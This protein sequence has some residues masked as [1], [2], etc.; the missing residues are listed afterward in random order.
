MMPSYLYDALGDLTW[1]VLRL[2]ETRRSRSSNGG[3]SPV[4]GAGSCRGKSM[5]STGSS[6]A[7]MSRCGPRSTSASKFFH[8]TCKLR[9][10]ANQLNNQLWKLH[11]NYGPEGYLQLW[12]NNRF[13]SDAWQR[14]PAVLS[15][16]SA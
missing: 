3:M 7:W 2:L 6:Y 15:Q 8:A 10:F 11:G 12:K 4:A 16:T 5:G 14:L 9:Q 13:P 1:A